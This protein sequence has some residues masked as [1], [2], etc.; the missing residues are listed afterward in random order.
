MPSFLEDLY[1]G[2]RISFIKEGVRITNYDIGHTVALTSEGLLYATNGSC[3]FVS[4]PEGLPFRELARKEGEKRLF[5]KAIEGRAKKPCFDEKKWG[6]RSGNT[7]QAI[8]IPW[9]I[10]KDTEA[11]YMKHASVEKACLTPMKG[12]KYMPIFSPKEWDTAKKE[13]ELPLLIKEGELFLGGY[14]ISR[15]HQ[16]LYFTPGWHTKPW[17][18]HLKNNGLATMPRPLEAALYIPDQ[19]EIAMSNIALGLRDGKRRWLILG[20]L[21]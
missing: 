16:G 11:C 15:V 2:Y 19:P 18:F 5:L 6:F 20:G 12:L 21:A 7:I 3:F 13:N 14:H 17:C 8:G 9:Q 4:Q 10:K 1:Y